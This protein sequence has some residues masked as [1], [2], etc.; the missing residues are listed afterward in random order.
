MSFSWVLTLKLTWKTKWMNWMT[1]RSYLFLNAQ[2]YLLALC[3]WR[4]FIK[5]HDPWVYALMRTLKCKP[6]DHRRSTRATSCFTHAGFKTC[7]W[8]WL[9]PKRRWVVD[10]NIFVSV[11]ERREHLYISGTLE[12]SF[13]RNG[14]ASMVILGSVGNIYLPSLKDL[15]LNVKK[16]IIII[17]KL[18][19]WYTR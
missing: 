5:F 8:H 14:L 7:C 12:L 4:E 11:T 3:S 17:K 10:F 2:R 9:H 1:L 19:W 6:V 13:E 15:P 16:I 18:W